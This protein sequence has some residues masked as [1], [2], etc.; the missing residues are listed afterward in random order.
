MLRS[1]KHSITFGGLC[2]S[3]PCAGAKVPGPTVNPALDR[4]AI[5]T[6]YYDNGVATKGQAECPD[7]DGVV[8]VD[9]LLTAEAMA[10]L[11]KFCFE[12]TVWHSLMKEGR[13]LAAFL[14]D[15]FAPPLLAQIVR[16]L[17]AAFPRFLG[18]YKLRF[19]WA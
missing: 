16:D 10:A 3:L 11:R 5:E 2:L 13:Y 6:E 8:V 19:A 9:E 15:G 4:Q 7:Q 14:D 12:S 17:Q 1:L 18:R